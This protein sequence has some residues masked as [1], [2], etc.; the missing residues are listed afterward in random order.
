[1]HGWRISKYPGL[2]GEGGLYAEG[3]WHSQGHRVIYLG[4]HPALALAETMAHMQLD[5]PNIPTTLKLIRVDIADG[6]TMDVTPDLPEG[7]QANEPATR[8]IGSAW[9]KGGTALL[10]PVPSAIL[11]HS[12]NYIIN[13]EHPQAATHLT[14]SLVEPFFIDQRFF[15]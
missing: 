4:E 15:R 11:A 10:M 2:T 14:E 5:L 1:M 9:L 8:A 12:T 6:A 3:R 13:P 7:W